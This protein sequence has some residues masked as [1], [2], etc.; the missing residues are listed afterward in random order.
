MIPHALTSSGKDTWCTPADMIAFV[1]ATY[2]PI[3]VDMAALAPTAVVPSYFGPD[4]TDPARR[5][6]LAWNPEPLP[7]G[8]YA[9]HLWCN[10]PYSKEAGGLYAWTSAMFLWA[11]LG[12]RVTATFFAKTETRAWH[13]N[14]VFAQDVHLLRRRQKFVDPETGKA[15]KAGAPQASAIVHW[16][17]GF[18]AR[19]DGP[20]Y[21]HVDLKEAP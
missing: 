14:V 3:D 1:E 21:Y 7:E 4:H 9:P 13:E 6:S 11:C 16:G 17:A 19:P 10:C 5:D 20:R 18:V 2:G 8:A 15:A 12:Y